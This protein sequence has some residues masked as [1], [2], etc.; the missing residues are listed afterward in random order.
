LTEVADIESTSQLDAD[1]L[2]DA[3]HW[4]PVADEIAASTVIE[5]LTEKFVAFRKRVQTKR[6]NYR[7]KLIVLKIILKPTS[8][9]KK[10]QNMKPSSMHS[11]RRIP[12]TRR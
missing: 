2:L 3:I 11:K 8:I 5:N 4:N 12:F 1:A 9:W 7:R 6:L 10:L